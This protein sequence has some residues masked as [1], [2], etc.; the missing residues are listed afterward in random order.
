MSL[1][2]TTCRKCNG[3]S[4]F[5]D[6]RGNNTGLYCG[7]CGSWQKWLNKDE[8]N[9]W[10]HYFVEL[11]KMRISKSNKTNRCDDL[12]IIERINR[13]LKW[14]NN[15]INHEKELRPMVSNLD[16]VRSLSYCF[17]LQQIKIGLEN[18]IIGR[19]YDDDGE[20]NE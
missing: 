8:I 15:E 12:T 16:S 6:Q 4:F 20:I 19:E 17:A 14:I 2:D 13:L 10:K 3:R 11:D 7:D 18:I 9:A 1:N 5:I